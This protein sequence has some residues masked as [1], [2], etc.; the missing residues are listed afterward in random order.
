MTSRTSTEIR[1]PL[2]ANPAVRS[3]MVNLAKDHPEAA[4]ALRAALKAMADEFKADA[5][6]AWEKSKAPM[7]RYYLDNRDAARTAMVLCKSAS[8]NAKHL[9][10]ILPK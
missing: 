2:A 4:K 3:I 1:N 10:H 5:T 7:A 6:K 8:V 9:A